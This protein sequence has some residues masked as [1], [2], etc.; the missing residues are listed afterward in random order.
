[1]AI[2]FTKNEGGGMMSI[3]DTAAVTVDTD[4]VSLCSLRF[5]FTTL[6]CFLLAATGERYR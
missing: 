3:V 4:V 1:M 5:A 6:V 2:I